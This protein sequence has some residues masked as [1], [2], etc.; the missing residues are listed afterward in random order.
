[1]WKMPNNPA[2][3]DAERI[4]HFAAMTSVGL[5][6]A[7]PAMRMD[8]VKPMPPIMP[9][10]TTWFQV[11]RFGSLAKPTL[12]STQVVRMMP[13]GLPRTAPKNTPRATLSAKSADRSIP[14]RRTWAFT[15]AK[16][17]SIR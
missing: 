7:S 17:G 15:K 9:T 10:A 6:K 8:I 12:T 1:M 14:T 3:N 16:I 5:E 13:T 2:M 4:A 11:T